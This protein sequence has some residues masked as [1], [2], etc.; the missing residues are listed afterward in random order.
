[1][2]RGSVEIRRIANN[3]S[4]RATFGKRCAGLLKKAH[5]LAVLCDADLGVLV[6]DAAGRQFHYC[7]PNASWSELIQRYDSTTSDQFQG[8]Q[9]MNHDHDQLLSEIARLRQERDHLE[10]VVR[11]QTGEDLPS[12]ASVPELG[13]LDQKLERALGKVR[14]MKDKLLEEQLGESHHRVH[15]LEDQ[16]SFLRHMMSEEGRQRAAVEA[17][18]VVAELMAPATLFGDSSGGGGGGGDVAAALAVAA[19]WPGA[20]I[21][22]D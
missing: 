20:V 13:H 21:I 22:H 2:R 9:G 15:I 18:A 6:F 19:S 11:S 12:T 1:M 10:A 16:N 7:S 5:E 14:E 4:R 17:S 8:G 3:V